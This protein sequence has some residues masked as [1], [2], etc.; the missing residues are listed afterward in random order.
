[1]ATKLLGPREQQYVQQRLGNLPRPVRLVVFGRKGCTSCEAAAQLAGELT[2]VVPQLTADVLL[3]EEP[4]AAERFT[5]FGIA[6]VPA[7]A[8]TA[9]DGSGPDNGVR[10][11]GFP[12]GYEFDSL[13]DAIRRVGQGSPGVEG[14]LARYLDEQRA[15]LHLQ[16]FITPTCPYCPRMV[17]LANRMALYSPRVRAEMVDALEFPELAEQ[18]EVRGVPL[19]VINDRIYVEGA[20]PEPMLLEEL[21]AHS[22]VP[23]H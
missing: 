16:V 18:H 22:I 8:V 10:F 13:L 1:M 7:L 21:R 15:P 2:Q 4:I 11:Y 19:T 6:R 9:G 3:E 23:G 20:V 5:R 17:Q 14:E 12:G